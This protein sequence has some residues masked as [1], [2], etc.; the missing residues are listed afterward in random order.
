MPKLNYVPFHF[1][2]FLILGIIFGDTFDIAMHTIFFFSL[3]NFLGLLF[4]FFKAEKSFHF[5]LS[6]FTF[7]ATL[8]ICIG[9]LGIDLANPKNQKNHYSNFLKERNR[10]I[11]R[12]HKILKPNNYYVKMEAEVLQ[13]DDQCT[14]GKILLQVERNN[15]P[16]KFQVDDIIF[17]TNEFLKVQGA[18]K[19][20]YICCKKKIRVYSVSHIPLEK[21]SIL[22]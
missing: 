17:T 4:F 2:F 22:N 5:P 13:L 15:L 11:V 21:K 14:K 8:F 9:I 10:S 3:L 6:F 7:T 12:I 20:N 18:L 19:K 1:T 16:N